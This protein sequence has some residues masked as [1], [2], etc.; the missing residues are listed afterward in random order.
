M[1]LD[2]FGI[3]GLLSLDALFDLGE[4]HV[5]V[6]SL[7]VFF[8]KGILIAVRVVEIADSVVA[9]VSPCLVESQ[10]HVKCGVLFCILFNHFLRVLV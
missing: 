8:D 2:L 3:L 6:Y 5:P 9:D 1:L 4:C 10:L 7:L